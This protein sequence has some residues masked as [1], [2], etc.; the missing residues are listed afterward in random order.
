MQRRE[1]MICIRWGGDCAGRV[2][3]IDFVGEGSVGKVYSGKMTFNLS[4][5]MWVKC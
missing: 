2:L 3:N 4:L 1:E 5:K